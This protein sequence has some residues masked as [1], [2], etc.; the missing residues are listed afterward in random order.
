M[1]LVGPLSAA[2][3]EAVELISEPEIG[4]VEDE[5]IDVE[6]NHEQ[7]QQGARR[8]RVWVLV[9]VAEVVQGLHDAEGQVADG[10]EE[11]DVDEHDFCPFV[12]VLGE[13]EG[14]VEVVPHCR[15]RPCE[16]VGDVVHLGV[17]VVQSRFDVNGWFS[18][19]RAVV[20]RTSSVKQIN[21]DLFELTASRL[22]YQ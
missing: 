12:R 3:E 4:D 10:E 16:E 2:E 9:F 21:F 19:K 14:V 11:G 20:A 6:A 22:S 7:H 17:E 1:L 15:P 18:L 13:A 8:L 5:G